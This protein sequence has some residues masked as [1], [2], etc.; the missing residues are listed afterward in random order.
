MKRV[1]CQNRKEL[2]LKLIIGLLIALLFY[3]GLAGQI[4]KRPMLFYVGTYFWIVLVIVYYSLGFPAKM[5]EWFTGYFMD[6]FQRGAFSTATFMIVMFLGVFVKHNDWSRKMM[7]IRGELSIIACILVLCHNVLFGIVYFPSLFKHPE[8]MTMQT[9]IASI[10]TLVL[11]TLMLP[12]FITSFKSVRKTMKGKTW[13]KV[14]RLAYPFFL[15][16]YVHVMVLYSAAVKEHMFDIVLY[17]A[18]YLSYVV[19]RLRKAFAKSKTKAV[20]ESLA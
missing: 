19:L 3:T 10:I 14:Q 17:S 9:K 7:S 18:I 15:L 20:K 1:C 8:L 13:K 2:L 11:L 5:P 12:L 4:K 6:V 16:I